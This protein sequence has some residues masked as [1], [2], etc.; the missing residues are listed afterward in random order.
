MESEFNIVIDKS[1][2]NRLTC[3]VT[4][5]AESYDDTETSIQEGNHTYHCYIE[6]F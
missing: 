3:F 6:K 2:D 4:F 1:I 5:V